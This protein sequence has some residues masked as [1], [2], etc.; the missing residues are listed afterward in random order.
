[1]IRVFENMFLLSEL[2]NKRLIELI[3]QFDRS[4]MGDRKLYEIACEDIEN[5]LMVNWDSEIRHLYDEEEMCDNT[6][7]NSNRLLMSKIFYLKVAEDPDQ[8][9]QE[10]DAFLSLWYKKWIERVKIVWGFEEMGEGLDKNQMYVQ[11]GDKV[12]SS[13]D[14]KLY[15]EAAIF[16]LIRYGEYVGTQILANNIVRNC[17]GKKGLISDKIEE[18]VKF[19][20]EVIRAAR[21]MAQTFGKLLFIDAKGVNLDG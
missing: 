6:V 20:I 1:M 4:K 14:I 8:V 12:L 21:G 17:A 11:R 3:P 9:K 2:V 5:F 10:I 18:K 16:T 7:K 13:E 19:Q 15:E